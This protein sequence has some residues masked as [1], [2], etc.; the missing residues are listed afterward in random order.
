MS[1]YQI[2]INHDNTAGLAA[3]DPQPA[4]PDAVQYPEIRNSAD[5]GAVFHGDP[6]IDLVWTSLTREQYNA[7]MTQ[8]GLSQTVAS[9]AI[10]ATIRDDNDAFSNYNATALH[11]K[12]AKRGM[13]FWQKLTIRYRS[14]VAIT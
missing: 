9:C 6:Y 14:L 2:A 3:I 1:L 7:L 10:T 4:T 13:A 11:L 12:S 5:G 8:H